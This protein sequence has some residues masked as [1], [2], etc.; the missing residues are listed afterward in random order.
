MFLMKKAR[1]RKK[2]NIV[3]IKQ[4]LESWIK[5]VSPDWTPEKV[6]DFIMWSGLHDIAYSMSRKEISAQAQQKKELQGKLTS[7]KLNLPN[8]LT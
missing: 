8:L 1:V 2:E 4:E 5:T 3:I 6:W 7:L